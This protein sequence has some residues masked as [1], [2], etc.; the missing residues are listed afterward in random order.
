MLRRKTTFLIHL[1]SQNCL[2][3]QNDKISKTLQQQ[4]EQHNN[5]FTT[6]T[7]ATSSQ[8]HQQNEIYFIGNDNKGEMSVSFAK[9]FLRSYFPKILNENEGLSGNKV[10]ELTP[11]INFPFNKLQNVKKIWSCWWKI[12]KKDFDEKNLIS[13]FFVMKRSLDNIFTACLEPL[14]AHYLNIDSFYAFGVVHKWRHGLKGG[15]GQIF[16]NG[17]TKAFVL[18]RVTMGGKGV[19]NC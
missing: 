9:L 5:T 14:K 4:W 15:G 11:F 18:K 10:P 12:K 8:Q 16:C 17:S 19:K 2:N 13:F 1:T 6:A 7:T 3:A